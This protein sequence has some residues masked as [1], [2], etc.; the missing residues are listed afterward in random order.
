VHHEW[1]AD[2]EV[3]ERI[4]S[5]EM[6]S[7]PEQEASSAGRDVS[8]SGRGSWLVSGTSI[9]GKNVLVALRVP[10]RAHVHVWG[11]GQVHGCSPLERAG[12]NATLRDAVPQRE[13]RRR[14]AFDHAKGIS[15]GG[16]NACRGK[17]LDVSMLLVKL[18]E[19]V[20][21]DA[22]I[23]QLQCKLT[24]LGLAVILADAKGSVL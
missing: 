18:G 17:L 12:D 15:T 24:R 10:A 7:S 16:R 13:S 23:D 6:R 22:H 14:E 21:N 1:Q 9:L 11:I 2:D 19:K 4:R 5:L 20:A 3:L 8:T